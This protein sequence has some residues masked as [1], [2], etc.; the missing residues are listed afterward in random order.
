MI[1]GDSYRADEIWYYKNIETGETIEINR[2]ND[3]YLHSEIED[4]EMF[5]FLECVVEPHIKDDDDWHPVKEF[6][7]D[8]VKLVI[9]CDYC[10]KH[11][12]DTWKRRRS[13]ATMFLGN[14]YEKDKSPISNDK[15][16]DLYKDNC[17][18][19]R[20]ERIQE[21]TMIKHGYWHPSETEEFAESFMDRFE[22]HN[23][24]PTSRGQ[25]YLA[26]LLDAELNVR[27]GRFFADMVVEEVVIEY[28][29]GGHNLSVLKGD[30]T[31]QEFDIRERER[32]QFMLDEGYRMLRVISNSE[33]FPSDESYFEDILYE[34]ITQL[35][36]GEKSEIHIV[37]SDSVNDP[38]HGKLKPIKNI[39]ESSE[40]G[41]EL[42]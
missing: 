22:K 17:K 31:Q 40:W 3:F 18:D 32:T 4:N 10:Q 24:V 34:A 23:S 29:G 21:T 26:K 1:I 25:R 13:R 38:K 19:C 33:Y 27:M 37:F 42:L 39:L 7:S 41:E 28:D 36:L 8:D 16:I 15:N 12:I 6:N 35:C 5:E 20:K 2:W 11:F 9:E 30:L 14:F